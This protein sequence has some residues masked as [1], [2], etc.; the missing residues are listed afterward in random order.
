MNINDND[1][2]VKLTW[3]SFQSM[4]QSTFD[5]SSHELIK[6]DSLS[7]ETVTSLNFYPYIYNKIKVKQ[8]LST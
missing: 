3:T 4:F 6:M 1:N 7:R 8:T 5:I 2:N